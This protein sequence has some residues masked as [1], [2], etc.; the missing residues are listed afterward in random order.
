[1]VEIVGCMEFNSPICLWPDDTLEV[2]HKVTNDENEEVLHEVKSTM[3]IS[4]KAVWTHSIL[5]K[6][7]GHLNHIIGDRDTLAWLESQADD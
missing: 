4:E 3:K 7:N 5:F 1:M 2:V 6:L